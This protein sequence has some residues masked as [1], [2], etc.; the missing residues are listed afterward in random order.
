ML[1]SLVIAPDRTN[2]PFLRFRFQLLQTV[3]ADGNR[4][5]AIRVRRAVVVAVAVVVT[6]TRVRSR[7]NRT[8]PPVGTNKIFP[9]TFM[10]SAR[11]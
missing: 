2:L 8:Q 11:H 3:Q 5:D 1:Y 6:V 9:W 4:T 10:A 7:V